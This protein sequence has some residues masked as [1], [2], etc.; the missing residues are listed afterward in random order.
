MWKYKIK[1]AV[2]EGI[3]SCNILFFVKRL[4][5]KLKIFKNIYKYYSFGCCI[6][7]KYRKESFWVWKEVEVHLFLMTISLSLM[8]WNTTNIGIDRMVLAA[9]ATLQFPGKNSHRCG[10]CVTF[11][12][13]DEWQIPWRRNRPGLQLR[14]K[15][16]HDFTAKLPLLSLESPGVGGN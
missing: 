6:G 10:T 16:L 12:F 2:F 3:S 8:V 14:Y 5:K 15:S 4:K 9:G 13:I 1:A 11:D 7:W